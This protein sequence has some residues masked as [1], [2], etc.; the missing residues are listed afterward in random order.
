MCPGQPRYWDPL[1]AAVYRNAHKIDM[2]VR[3]APL[4]VPVLPHVQVAHGNV[5]SNVLPIQ[6]PAV[7]RTMAPVLM[8]R[9]GAHT[10]KP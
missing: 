3:A 7:A 2:Q 6:V 4:G 1:F 5:A 9:R 8:L 10:S